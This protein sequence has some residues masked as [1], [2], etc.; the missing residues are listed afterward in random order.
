MKLFDAV[1][2]CYWSINQIYRYL[3]AKFVICIRIQAKVNVNISKKLCSLQLLEFMYNLIL[4][5]AQVSRVGLRS[6]SAG[7]PLTPG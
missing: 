4:R 7:W 1:N 2:F 6:Y 3:S 5:H